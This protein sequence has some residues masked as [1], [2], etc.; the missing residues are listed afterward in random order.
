MIK[1]TTISAIHSLTEKLNSANI[2]LEPIPGTVLANAVEVSLANSKPINENYNNIP[3]AIQDASV[4]RNLKNECEHD[5]VMDAYIEEGAKAIRQNTQIARNVVNPMVK[6][7]LSE[8]ES[9]LKNKNI[10]KANQITILV[11]NVH[12]IFL[13]NVFDGMIA[14]YKEA[15]VS[16]SKIERWFPSMDQESLLAYVRTGSSGFD[17][18]LDV[19]LTELGTD[20]VKST[21]YTFFEKNDSFESGPYRYEKLLD[22]LVNSDRNT[23]LV[24]HLM[25]RKLIDGIPDGIVGVDLVTYKDYV[26]LVLEQSG[27][28]LNRVLERRAS[29][30]QMNNLVTQYPMSSP[31]Y[32]TAE[33]GVIKVNGALYDDWLEKG[34]SPEVIFG[35]YVSGNY[36]DGA[37]NGNDLLTKKDDY[38]A[39][40]GRHSTL[41][42]SQARANVF[43]ATIV[44][45][46]T[47]V[48][49]Q[50]VELGEDYTVLKS[51]A[52]YHDRL[53]MIIDGIQSKDIEDL[54]ILIRRVVCET[55]FAHTNALDILTAIDEEGANNPNIDPREAALLAQI[56]LVAEWVGKQI[57][58][59]V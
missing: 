55:M 6:S 17:K 20:V 49:R 58:V 31:E 46:K 11:D 5:Q 4:A 32:V 34:G 33:T 29:D 26:S 15:P 9:I 47:A 52:E 18:D 30:I 45:I 39:A 59:V 53:N 2:C 21:Y 28:A 48:A 35:A 10:Q 51:K 8:T 14:K 23:I 40:W 50:I 22:A 27:R 54:Y 16:D 1:E 38:L 7:V 43:H 42:A 12:P 25:A 44:A 24:V 13:S 41:I 19:Y 36:R 37:R 3:V 57:K 56:R